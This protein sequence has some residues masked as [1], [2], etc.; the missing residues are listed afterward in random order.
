MR[1]VKRFLIPACALFVLAALL[2]AAPE[3][4]QKQFTAQQ[5]AWWAFQKLSNPAPPAISNASSD[6]S[7]IRTPVAFIKPSKLEGRMISE[8]IA[9]LKARGSSAVIDEDFAHDIKGGI[10]GAP[11]AMDAA[12]LG[13]VLDSSILSRSLRVPS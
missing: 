9:D 6:A 2:L 8:V 5:R 4:P 1:L 7:W 10:K 3:P 13:L 11:A 12:L